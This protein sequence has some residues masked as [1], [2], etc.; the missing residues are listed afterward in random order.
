[1]PPRNKPNVDRFARIEEAQEEFSPKASP[2]PKKKAA[3]KKAPPSPTPEAVAPV[4]IE[5]PLR[6]AGR[7]PNTPYPRDGRLYCI[8]PQEICDRL[9]EF[10]LAERR[11]RRPT[12]FDKSVAVEEALLDY[13]EKHG[14]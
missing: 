13:L 5:Q 3:K 7:A 1:M 8:M 10:V 14:A 6:Q 2:T 9:D 11:R 4:K 12:P